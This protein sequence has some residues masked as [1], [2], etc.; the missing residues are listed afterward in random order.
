MK[1]LLPD[2]TRALQILQK[3]WLFSLSTILVLAIGIGAN[4]IVFS[5]INTLLIKPLPYHN[6]DRL[7]MLWETAPNSQQNAPVAPP[8]FSD[9]NKRSEVFEQA[10]AY[11]RDSYNLSGIDRSQHVPIAVV[12]PN[13]F[14][15]FQI[16]PALGR[17]FD[18]SEGDPGRDR[19]AVLQHQFWQQHFGSSS[20]VIGK[21]IRLDGENY[22]IIGVAPPSFAFPL[23][24]AAAWIP[25]SFHADSSDLRWRGSHFL[26]IIGELKPGISLATAQDRLRAIAA[27]LEKEFPASNRG[28]SVKLVTLQ[29]ELTGNVHTA[30][31]LLLG[32]LVFVLLIVC[33]NIAN[34]LLS[35][36]T[37]RL[38]EVSVRM[39]LGASRYQ[40]VQQ[41][42]AE[43]LI[44]SI[45][46]GGLGYFLALSGLKVSARY[47]PVDLSV[48][49]GVQADSNVILFCLVLAVGSGVIFGVVP[50]LRAG[51]VAPYQVLK[52]T[53][54]QGSARSY[55]AQ[56]IFI[57]TQCSL[58][59]VLISGSFLAIR[60]LLGLAQTDPGFNSRNLLT[61][62][63]SLPQ[64]LY[65]SENKIDLF[66]REMLE[67][68]QPLP[69][70][71][72]VALVNAIPSGRH[73][74]NIVTL[75]NTSDAR[76]AIYYVISPSYFHTMQIPVR[77]GRVFSS[78]DSAKAPLAV[79]LN[80]S[81]VRSYFGNTNPLGKK[82]KLAAPDQ[83]AEWREIVGVVGDI[84]DF[85][86]DKPPQP[87]FYLPMEQD[88]AHA[89]DM[90]ILVRTDAQNFDSMASIIP[91]LVQKL[92][93]EQPIFRIM[94][95]EDALNH[96]LRDRTVL[97]ALL[98][99][100]AAISLLL[101]SIGIFGLI[102]YLVSQRTAEIGIRMA[103]GADRGSIVYLM[104]RK[105]IGLV[106]FGIG[107]GFVLST[108]LERFLSSL[109]SNMRPI[110]PLAWS[111][112]A[113]T[114]LVFASVASYLPARKAANLNPA[115]ALRSE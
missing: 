15:F 6:A 110:D 1:N 9:Y 83:A 3:N 111:A 72:D 7:V 37:A 90:N 60:A 2:V 74:T 21:T 68:I 100:F 48:F 104:L 18:A 86:L 73:S 97:S 30:I 61:M 102:S 23:P 92:D 34:L 99:G 85:G 94:P 54:S 56:S 27:Q 114:L 70:I 19:V 64:S 42:L 29:Q 55:L 13:F 28:W 10:T 22:Q 51:R 43:S 25:S 84:R 112:S 33:A 38:R 40:I 88:L 36:G 89:T 31:V 52:A 105:S 98:T 46:G 80:D 65:P 82:L 41:L 35:R 59:L 96:V 49:G 103:L 20:S 39:A 113:I 5:L 69:R 50:A 106:L 93:S 77:W 8:N 115:Q 44:L 45:C 95:M 87:A 75:E 53:S 57:V 79:I 76:F 14:N 108:W 4:M 63:V 71:E 78:Q 11:K 16:P 66:Y 26:Q 24:D 58:A 81:F 101:A 12:F 32:A 17:T 47:V 109:L 107:I 67:S 91:K 62:A